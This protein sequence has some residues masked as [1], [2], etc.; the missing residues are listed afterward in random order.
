MSVRFE[1][2]AQY[3]RLEA[4]RA[5]RM[6]RRAI[7]QRGVEKTLVWDS[8]ISVLTEQLVAFRLKHSR[9]V[10]KKEDA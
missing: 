10:F 8:G 1:W 3:L 2:G 5:G 9:L 4:D 6:L 7:V